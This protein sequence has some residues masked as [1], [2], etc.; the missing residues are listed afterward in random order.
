MSEAVTDLESLTDLCTPWCIHVVVTLRIAEAI[1]GGVTD[2]ESLAK[3]AGC[4]QDVLHSIMGHLV[5]KGVF[6]EPEFGRFEL[7][8]ASQM[9]LH[10]GVRLSLDLNGIGG[11]MAHAWGTLLKYAQTGKPAYQDIFGRPFWDDLQANPEVHASFDAMIGPSGHGS[12]NPWFEVTGGWDSIETVADVG[13]GT[14]AMLAEVLHARPG[15]NGFLIDMPATIERAHETFEKAGLQNRVTYVPQSFF[16]PL[17]VGLD[18]YL[19]RGIINDWADVESAQILRRCAEAARPHGRVV[20]LKSVSEDGTPKRLY[21]E[22]VLAGGKHRTISEFRKLA[23]EAS[24]DVVAAGR[25]PSG[26]Y[27]VECRPT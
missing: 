19:L 26:Y 10:P 15:V 5:S 21:I 6:D 14:G 9:L 13:G 18:I 16:E 22:M 17:P 12:F 25:Q 2:I 3:G 8:D 4:D 23:H 7:N 27:V 20:I 11:R 1:A 24:L